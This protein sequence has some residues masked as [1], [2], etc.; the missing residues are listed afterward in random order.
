MGG[1]RRKLLVIL[2][3]YCSGFASALYAL[4]PTSRKDNEATGFLTKLLES[5][6]RTECKSESW[7]ENT[8]T[9]GENKITAATINTNIEKWLRFAEDKASKVGVLIKMKL[10][11]RQ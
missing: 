9:Q 1:I 3:I 7:A 8:E 11:E 2:I 5:S 4:A 6:Q 10:A